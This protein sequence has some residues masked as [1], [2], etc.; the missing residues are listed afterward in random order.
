MVKMEDLSLLVKRLEVV[1]EKLEAASDKSGNS[2]VAS[3][4][5]LG[6]SVTAFD[7]IVSGTFHAFLVCC[8]KIGEDVATA[9]PMIEKAFNAQREFL[10]ISS[11]SKEPSAND[12]QQLLTPTAHIIQEIQE[13]R[14]RMRR[15]EY[16]NHLSAL[17]E[18][19]PALGWVTVSPAP[20]PFVL[21]MN[22]A[23]QFYTNRVLKDWKDKS[24]IHVEWVKAWLQVITELQAYVKQ[25]HT[26][27][28]VWNKT[29]TAQDAI[30]VS[31]TGSSTPASGGPPKPPPSPP[32]G[33]PAPP[34]P[35]PPSTIDEGPIDSSGG[36]NALLESLN[37]GGDITSG[38][39]KVTDE[40]K[41]HK[42]PNLRTESV[43][44]AKENN[45]IQTPSQTTSVQKARTEL[46]GKRWN[47]EHHKGD[48][49]IVIGETETNQS[50]YVYKC[51]NCTI[52]VGGKCNNIVLDGCKKTGLVFQSVVAGV[53][54]INCQ[55]VK[56]QVLGTTPTISVDKADGCQM[57]LS[58][59]SLGVDLITAKYS[60]LNLM[61]PT[62][63]DFVEQP[64]PEQFITRVEGTK[65]N[66]KPLELSINF[67]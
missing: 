21:E 23:G 48:Q 5:K 8:D 17:S 4:D 14:E 3:D 24:H 30:N 41:T 18:A 38:L 52:Q 42:N 50:V 61:I 67:V 36:R 56:I 57:F 44:K 47:V 63:D 35:P 54:V 55:S 29:Q 37:K 59:E 12:L 11:L 66:T 9:K 60:E 65:L 33:P 49:N 40:E 22:H 7:D 64:V 51:D 25:F 10:R 62:E 15:S 26:T 19:I 13:F 32:A 46:D 27:G 45:T 16:F 34:P 39:R 1:T 31:K 43:V 6:L 20:A 28:L 53:E 58:K 2:K